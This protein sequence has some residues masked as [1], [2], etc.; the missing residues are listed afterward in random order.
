MS[1]KASILLKWNCLPC[2]LILGVC[3]G[4]AS[5]TSSFSRSFYP[6]QYFSVILSSVLLCIW[7]FTL[8]LLFLLVSKSCPTLWSHGLQHPRLSCLSLSPRICANSC[9]L[10]QWCYLNHLILCCP[11]FLLSST[12]PSIRVFSSES[13]FLIRWPKYCSFSFSI[14]PSNEYLGF[15]SFR[16]DWSQGP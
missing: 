15:I 1:D 2:R 13:T 4:S 10:C 3:R 14:S 6:L 8:P 11:L 5:P 16:I 12:C 9:P 7:L